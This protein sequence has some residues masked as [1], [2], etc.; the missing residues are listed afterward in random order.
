MS[1]LA[2]TIIGISGLWIGWIIDW[3]VNQI[4]REE[5]WLA[6]NVCP[7]CGEK[8]QSWRGWIPILRHIGLQ[9]CPKCDHIYGRRGF[10][11]ELV[12]AVSILVLAQIFGWSWLT[13]WYILVV[14]ILVPIA[15][16]DIEFQ[17]IPDSLLLVGLIPV[18]GLWITNYTT[19]IL[20]YILGGLV[21]GAG[22]LTVAIVGRWIYK[23]DVMGFGDV[24]FVAWMGLILGWKIGLVALGLG[25]FLATMIF[26]V[27]MPL[28]KVRF[29]Q[30]VPFG[31]FLV[32]GMY[33]G[34][35]YG[36]MLLDWYLNNFVYI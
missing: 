10:I 25:F 32:G 29:K 19:A 16:I 28:G 35:I 5:R 27:M 13:L 7:K 8:H 17:I 11:I 9:N 18:A 2:L 20:T 21:L 24:K 3:A 12:T 36:R 14:I 34:M 23:Q 6:P 33:L 15:A 1:P 4:P 30:E 31:P 26:L 22:L